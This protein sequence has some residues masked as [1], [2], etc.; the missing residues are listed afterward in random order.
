MRGYETI[1]ADFSA[2]SV[3]VTHPHEGLWAK[4]LKLNDV[5]VLCYAS[6]WGVMSSI[7]S[8]GIKFSV[9]LRIPMRGYEPIAFFGDMGQVELRI[10]MRGYELTTNLPKIENEAVTHPHEG[11]WVC[12]SLAKG[13]IFYCYASPWGVMSLQNSTVNTGYHI[14]THPH[15]GLWDQKRLNQKKRPP[16]RI[17]MRGY[18][19]QRHCLRYC[20]LMV[21]HPHEGLWDWQG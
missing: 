11:L 2:I 20:S 7:S 9:G 12:K 5:A 19:C 10:P 1:K 3:S 4:L 17:P 13:F 15:E 14:V 16:L 21:T 6:P 18:E 8:S